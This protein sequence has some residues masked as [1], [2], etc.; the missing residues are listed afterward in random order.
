MLQ[1]RNGDDEDEG[2]GAR[3]GD[4]EGEGGN[5]AG[6]TRRA[7]TTSAP[8]KYPRNV[9]ENLSSASPIRMEIRGAM[10]RS[11]GGQTAKW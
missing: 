6:S 2:N 10:R 11:R 5:G 1:D 3:E 8:A 4:G 7:F 9:R